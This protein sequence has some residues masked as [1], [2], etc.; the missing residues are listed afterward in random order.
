[1]CLTYTGF[2][3]EL[4]TFSASKVIDLRVYWNSPQRDL[5]AILISQSDV[6]TPD[7]RSSVLEVVRGD[8]NTLT[9]IEE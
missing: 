5:L 6:R 8:Q 2:G 7:L 9:A 3:I 4:Y 1:M